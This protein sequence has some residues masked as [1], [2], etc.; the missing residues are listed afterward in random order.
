[1]A[2]SINIHNIIFTCTCTLYECVKRIADMPVQC[3]L[4]CSLNFTVTVTFARGNNIRSQ[5]STH[6][7]ASAAIAQA[8]WSM[9]CAVMIYYMCMCLHVSVVYNVHVHVIYMCIML[10]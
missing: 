1:M 5:G 8:Q 10:Y 2:C 4:S 6:K 3:I 7:I 9:V